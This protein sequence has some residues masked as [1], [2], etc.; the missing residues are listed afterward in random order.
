MTTYLWPYLILCCIF[1]PYSL[2]PNC[3]LYFDLRAGGE[4]GSDKNFSWKMFATFLL[5]TTIS[6]F[7]PEGSALDIKSASKCLL[8]EERKGKA[9]YTV[10]TRGFK[11]KH[12]VSF[13]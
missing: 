2:K 12:K 6:A 1:L 11:Y 5:L 3:I 4:G 9:M 13:I 10:L 7:V 8:S